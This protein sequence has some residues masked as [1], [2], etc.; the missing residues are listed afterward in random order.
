VHLHDCF[1]RGFLHQFIGDR[2]GRLLSC[3]LHRSAAVTVHI[4]V[5]V[6]IM[7][8]LLSSDKWPG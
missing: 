7:A 1:C 4:A 8:T 5:L 3:D 2:A 6:V